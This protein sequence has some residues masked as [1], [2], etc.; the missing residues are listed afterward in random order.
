[1]KQR[2]SLILVALIIASFVILLSYAFLNLITIQSAV[3]QEVSEPSLWATT[4][5]LRESE[6]MQHQLLSP[7]DGV[8]ALAVQYEL[9]YSRMDVLNSGKHIEFF[10]RIQED[11]LVSQATALVHA[12]DY[13]DKGPSRSDNDD[14]ALLQIL[15]H[16]NGL[17]IDLSNV[18]NLRER[19]EQINRRSDQAA[20]MHLLLVAVIGALFTGTIMATLLLRNLKKL[21]QAQ[22]DLERH[23]ARLE[24]IVEQRT[25]E[26]RTSLEIERRAR[27][28]YRSFIVTISHQFRTPVSVIHMISQRLA[29]DEHPISAAKLQLKSQRILEAAQK[30]EHLLDGFLSASK[31][32]RNDIV[33][34]KKEIEFNSI[35]RIAADEVSI[36]FPE[37]QFQCDLGDKNIMIQ[38][39]PVFL[40]QVVINIL[41]NAA[42][43]SFAPS[44]IYLTLKV[45]KDQVIL[46]IKDE[47]I[48]IPE[49]AQAAI[50]ER[51]YRAVNVHCYPGLGVGLSLARD[52]VTMH[53]GHVEMTSELGKGSTFT[54]SLPLVG[55]GTDG[56]PAPE[57]HYPLY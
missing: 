3:R 7:H 36:N 37:R 14:Q 2:K 10:R 38:G 24:D 27:E 44:V 15:G 56:S 4:Q 1:M 53:D 42:K 48:G 21:T 51:F 9:L 49:A 28:V 31:L 47:G 46:S 12:M 55:V 45:E 11:D 22:T 57:C 17:L 20:A 26:L 19:N 39:D 13:I 54:V 52:I 35:V 41:E 25:S 43:Y 16:L 30:L 34:K 8:H 32:D 50:F 18:T 33:I 5:A 40:E 6:E 23:R 29:R